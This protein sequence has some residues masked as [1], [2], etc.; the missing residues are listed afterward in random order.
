M[1]RRIVRVAATPGEVVDD[2]AIIKSMATDAFNHAPG[3]IF[4]NT[5]SQQF[6]RP[7]MGAWVDLWPGQ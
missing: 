6:G 2:I 4:M 3:Q 5:G 1:R 7:S